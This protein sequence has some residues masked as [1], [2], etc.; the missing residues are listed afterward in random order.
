MDVYTPQERSRVMAAVRSTDTEPERRVR[1]LLHRLGYRFRLHRRDLPGRPD[2][3]LPKW[4]AVLF[5]HGCFWHQHPNCPRAARPTSNV[6]FWN[7]KLDRNIRRDQENRRG[8]TEAGWHVLTLWECQADE[9][10]VERTVRAFFAGLR[11]S[12]P[13]A[14]VNA[15]G[16]DGVTSCS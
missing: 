2:I 8:L 13:A 6:E 5:V 1:R 14:S 12:G 10:N 4:R 11:P 3:V 16:P 15:S 7:R 9:V